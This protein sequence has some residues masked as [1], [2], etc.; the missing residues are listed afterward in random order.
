MHEAKSPNYP[1]REAGPAPFGGDRTLTL[2]PAIAPRGRRA[3]SATLQ[4]TLNNWA[5]QIEPFP[6]IALDAP[7]RG[8]PAKRTRPKE[9]QPSK[10]RIE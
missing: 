8:K 2:S 3:A 7:K 10:G 1:P 6:D 4:R 9:D 5:E